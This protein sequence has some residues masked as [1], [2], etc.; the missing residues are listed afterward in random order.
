MRRSM[1][2]PLL[3][4]AL[5]TAVASVVLFLLILQPDRWLKAIDW[6]KAVKDSFWP[7]LIVFVILGL[8]FVLALL[9]VV[10]ALTSGRIRSARARHTEYGVIDISTTALEN[11]ALNSAKAAQVGIKTAKAKVRTDSE[12][13]LNVVMS[14]I[15]YSDVEIPLQMQKIQERVRKDL[16]RYT[17]IPVGDVGVRVTR[18]EL[19]GAKVEK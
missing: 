10:Y 2:L 4:Y 19:I 6:L 11:I 8:I 9:S 16:E 5:V 13:R 12:R 14:V 1:R 15:L 17:G 18:V 3:T 7:R